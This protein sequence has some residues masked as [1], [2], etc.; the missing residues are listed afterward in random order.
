MSCR[1]QGGTLE[2]YSAQWLCETLG[3]RY[4]PGTGA[5]HRLLRDEASSGTPPVPKERIETVRV[6]QLAGSR[7]HTIRG[8]TREPKQLNNS[9]LPGVIWKMIGKMK[10]SYLGEGGNFECTSGKEKNTNSK[11]SI[12][13]TN[14]QK[15]KT[16]VTC[17]RTNHVKEK[18]V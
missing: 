13:K 1:G 4:T 5:G 15:V 16:L 8:S 11:I 10:L 7:R 2:H 12:P 6:G 9:F 17:Q 3:Q 14:Q 18:S